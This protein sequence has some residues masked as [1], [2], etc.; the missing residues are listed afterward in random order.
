MDQEVIIQLLQIIAKNTEATYSPLYIATIT[1]ASAIIV[2]GIGAY[3]LLKTAKKQNYAQIISA[4]RLRWLRV[5]RENIAQVF[6]LMDRQ[7]DLLRRPGTTQAQLDE[8]SEQIM[9]RVH[10]KT[11][12]LI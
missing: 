6:T 8:L 9:D 1:A 2:G 11:Q 4:E 7:A 10:C 12:D 5:I 3:G